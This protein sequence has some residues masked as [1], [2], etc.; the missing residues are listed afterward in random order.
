MSRSRVLFHMVRA[1]FLERI[2]RYSFLLT[3]G[4]SVYL[5]YA[6]FAGQ[7][8]MQLGSYH[9]VANSAWLGSVVGLVSA[10]FLSLIGFYV[11]KNTIQRDRETRVGQILAATPMSRSFYTLSKVLSNLAVLSAMIMILSAAAIVIQLTHKG[12]GRINLFDLLSPILIF[13]LGALS[14]TAAFAV[15]FETIP[16]LRGGVGNIAYFFL[17]C[18]LLNLSVK[19]LLTGKS[20]SDLTS[21]RDYTGITTISGQMQAQLRQ[22]DPEYKGGSGFYIGSSKRLPHPDCRRYL[23]S[24]RSRPRDLIVEA[25]KKTDCPSQTRRTGT[26]ASP[27]KRDATP[28]L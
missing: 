20:L 13:S 3:L 8:N 22:L 2:R 17:W 19:P 24:L 7:I 12:T 18:F 5:G 21:M 27:D 25:Q 9:G 26:A 11:V 6:M 16:G 15:L 1:D 14:V 4:F 28:C 23:R 10:V